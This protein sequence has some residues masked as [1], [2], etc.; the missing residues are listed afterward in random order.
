[1]AKNDETTEPKKKESILTKSGMLLSLHQTTHE[2]FMLSF[3]IEYFR[4]Y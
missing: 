2:K 3:R 1:M 4:K